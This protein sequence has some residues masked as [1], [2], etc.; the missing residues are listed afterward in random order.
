MS[1]SAPKKHAAARAGDATQAQFLPP[2]HPRRGLFAV[3]MGAM[4]LWVVFLLVLYFTTVYPQRVK[5]RWQQGEGTERM[6]R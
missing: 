6:T 2:P 5:E 3:L 4:V 1:R